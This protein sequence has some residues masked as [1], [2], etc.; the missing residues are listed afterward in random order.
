M[1]LKVGE[2]AALAGVSV[3]TL[4]HYD[5]I[6]LLPPSER[7]HAGY[8]LYSDDDLVTL[9]QILFFRELGFA[10]QEIGRIMH[11]PSF[12][13]LEALR[14]QRRMLVDRSA[15]LRKMIAAVD[16]AID[17]MGRG[18]VMD[19]SEMFEVFGD[20]DPAR[21]EDEV[22]ERWGH[23]EAY[24]ESARRTA[25]YEKQDWEAMKREADEINDRLAGLLDA[26]VLADDPRA[27]EEAEQHRLMMDRWF[28]PCSHSMHTGLG[29]MY[30]GDAR[31][32][33]TYEKVRPGLA[34]FFREAIKANAARQAG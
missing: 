24:R 14:L 25:S 13:R 30:V 23:S 12:D 22:Q 7:S 32:K 27:T 4:H 1:G 26:G 6:G 2:V 16:K 21:Y 9:Q 31:F 15:Q 20:F 10:L 28:Y 3:R 8:R 17:G 18:T 34:H 33:E 5:R 11:D 29:E 19:R